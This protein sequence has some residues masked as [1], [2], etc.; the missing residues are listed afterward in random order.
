MNKK[1]KKEKSSLILYFHDR[2]YGEKI[3]EEMKKIIKEKEKDA[4]T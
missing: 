4:K 3:I 1:I 2:K